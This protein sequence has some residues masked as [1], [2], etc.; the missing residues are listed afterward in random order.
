MLRLV[1]R[2]ALLVMVFAALLCTTSKTAT[3]DKL[4]KAQSCPQAMISWVGGKATVQC[5]QGMTPW[6]KEGPACGCNGKRDPDNQCGGGCSIESQWGEC[7]I[8]CRK[9][10]LGR[11]TPGRV[12]WRG[13]QQTLIPPRCSCT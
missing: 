1:T 6:C 12:E 4:P 13:Y 11:C 7:S 10:R 2:I 3:V 9:G 8:I 5:P